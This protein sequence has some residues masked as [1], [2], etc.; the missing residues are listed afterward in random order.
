MSSRSLRKIRGD[1][2][3]EDI[4]NILKTTSLNEEKNLPTKASQ[5]LN[6]FDLLNADCS[7]DEEANEDSPDHSLVE[8]PVAKKAQ[9]KKRKKKNKKK[10]KNELQNNE[11]VEQE[12]NFDAILSELD[13]ISPRNLDS[14]VTGNISTLQN[15]LQ[16]TTLTVI[17]KN[18]NAENE[19]RRMFGREAVDENRG[20]GSQFKKKNYIFATPKSNWPPMT[21]CGIQ[22]VVA[23]TQSGITYFKYV[24]S[25]SNYQNLQQIFWKAS[26]LADPHAVRQVLE[27]HPYHLDTLLHLSEVCRVSGDTQTASDLLNRALF[28][29]E[30]AFHPSFNVTS[31]TCRLDYNRTENRALFI[32]LFRQI[33]FVSLKSC[34]QTAFELSKFLYNLSPEQDPLACLLVIDTLALKVE[35]YNFVL[36]FIDEFNHS[37]KLTMLPNFAYSYSIAQ[38]YKEVVDGVSHEHSSDLLQKAILNYPM[39]AQLICEKC[40]F[41]IESNSLFVMNEKV[42][43]SHT[44][45]LTQQCKLYLERSVDLWKDTKVVHWFKHNVDIVN[46][47]HAD[48]PGYQESLHQRK[49]VFLSPP[50]NVMRHIFI[51][52][53]S[54]V[55]ALLPNTA[56]ESSQDPHDPMPPPSSYSDYQPGTTRPNAG[57]PVMAF[58]NSLMPGYDQNTQNEQEIGGV[59]LGGFLAP[60][61]EGNRAGQWGE[62]LRNIPGDFGVALRDMLA[63]LYIQDQ[64]NQDAMP[65]VVDEAQNDDEIENREIV[66]DDLD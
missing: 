39:V 40:S 27:I 49:T 25:K 45:S 44:R 31:V 58:I 53:I 17:R 63:N 48:M 35:D 46:T 18:L 26:H 43:K 28:C 21:K 52:D 15:S 10:Q 24:H 37:L 34:W 56:F 14:S 64:D 47:N 61:G 23:K 12:D 55:S 66:E 20:R 32:A 9:Q 13:A 65:E 57:N 7:S 8:T 4:K 29:L 33:L 5:S 54:A 62:Q 30:K 22:M 41:V 50:L 38:F 59:N 11:A 19:L 60:A 51:S 36:Q 1:K 16:S 3:L 42:L 2:D 6:V